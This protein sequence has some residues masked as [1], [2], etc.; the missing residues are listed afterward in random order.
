MYL[1]SGLPSRSY[2]FSFDRV[3]VLNDISKDRV[4]Y[5]VDDK[6]RSIF[7]TR[8]YLESVLRRH[9]DRFV[10]VYTIHGTTVYR[11]RHIYAGAIPGQGRESATCAGSRP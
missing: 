10:R 9:P 1:W 11:V 4:D 3:Y 6:L 7:T 5:I 8:L 2:S